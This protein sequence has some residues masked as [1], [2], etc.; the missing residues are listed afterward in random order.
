V[1]SFHPSG[2]YLL[3]GSK[4]AYLNCW[5]MSNDYKAVEKIPAHNFAIY[6]IA[7]HP[8]G[9]LFATGSRDKTVK[10]WNADD[11][12]FLLRIDHDKFQGHT[13]SVNALYWCRFNNYLISGGDDRKVFVWHIETD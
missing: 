3:S 8:E 5:D 10:I 2:N 11:L 4:D 13:H 9:K 7:W 12:S 1:V 6:A